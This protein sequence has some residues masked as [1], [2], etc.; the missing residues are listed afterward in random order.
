MLSIQH[1][2]LEATGADKGECFALKSVLE[3]I[4]ESLK[5]MQA[6]DFQLDGLLIF[7]WR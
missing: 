2:G 1:P 5:W 7:L 6:L 3:I 4:V